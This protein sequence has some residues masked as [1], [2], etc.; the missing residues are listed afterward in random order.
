MFQ[1]TNNCTEFFNEKRNRSI[2]GEAENTPHD[3]NS[4]VRDYNR[5]RQSLQENKDHTLVRRWR[6]INHQGLMDFAVSFV[7]HKRITLIWQ[8]QTM[9][10]KFLKERYVCCTKNGGEKCENYKIRTLR[11]TAYKIVSNIL[12]KRIQIYTKDMI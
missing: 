5:I 4:E 3:Q 2:T 7:M 12:Y 9:P 10:E 6:A 8:R 11:I 1:I